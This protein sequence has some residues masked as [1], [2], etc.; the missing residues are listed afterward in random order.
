MQRSAPLACATVLAFGTAVAMWTAGFLGRIPQAPLPGYVLIPVLAALA[1]AGGARAGRIPGMGVGVGALTGFLA[2][3]VNLLVLGSV[4]HGAQDAG[5]AAYLGVV[6]TLPAG[7]LLGAAGA[8][9]GRR[10]APKEFDATSAL[11]RVAAAATVVLVLVGGLVTSQDAG[12]AVVD[13]PNSFGYPMFLF[14]LARMVGGVFYEHAH[15][16]L[17]SLVGLVTLALALR[18]L[19]A[20]PRASV[21]AAGLGALALVI[22]QGILGGLRVTGHFTWSDSVEVTRPNL[23][24][25]MVHGATGQVFLALLAGLAAVTSRSWRELPRPRGNPA[26]ASL[27]RGL[28]LA[29][30]AALL[31]Q[32]AL[33]LRLRHLGEGLLIHITFAV[34]VVAL[35]TVASVRIVAQYEHLTPLRKSGAALVAH[36]MTQLV[37]GGV[38]F[39]AV[40][41]A[42]ES[43]P[44]LFDVLAATLHQTVGALL[45]A[46]AVLVA[47]WVRRLLPAAAPATGAVPAAAAPGRP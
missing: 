47:L 14:P 44:Q 7:A 23:T 45:L 37:L 34:A 6:A 26:D 28:S 25:A 24:L 32:L 22:L 20:D 10:L 29:V 11:A 30:I 13:W 18:L 17:G 43:G 12:L 41:R 5:T 40:S 4:L 8:A 2:S 39:L 3:V 38:A 15:R 35:V 46:N 27:D 21:K 1:F 19:F 42:R 33:G 31:V 36:A 16:L 9:F